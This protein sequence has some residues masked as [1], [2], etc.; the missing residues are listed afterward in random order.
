MKEAHAEPLLYPRHRLA[1]RRRRHAKLPSRN[2]ETSG[3][4]GLNEGIQRSQTVHPRTST[5]DNQVRYVWIYGPFFKPLGE[6]I[7]QPPRKEVTDECNAAR[8]DGEW[9]SGRRVRR[10]GGRRR[11]RRPLPARSPAQ[12][13]LQ[14][15]GIRGRVRHRRH[16]VLELLS[17]R[18]GRFVRAAVSIL[19]RGALAGLELQRALSFVGRASRLFPP[20][21]QEARSQP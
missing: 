2:R 7:C 6:F 4:R 17:G 9:E 19:Q 12:A 16:L 5:S 21:R 20:R 18:P 1:D 3:F 10:A 15:E 8:K 11:V 13:R 14:R